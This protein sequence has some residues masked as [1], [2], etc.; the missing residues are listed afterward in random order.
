[1]KID[2]LLQQTP[3]LP[4]LPQVVQELIHTM[5]DDDV[6]MH[7]VAHKL[8]ADQVLSA[9]VLRLANSA[10]YSAP[11]TVATVDEALRMLGFRTVRTLVVSAGMVG[12]FQ[13]I[14]GINMP[15]FWRYG[16][17][18]AVGAK[19]LARLAECDADLAFTVGLLHSIGRLVMAAG[20]AD[21]MAAI[22]AS[23]SPFQCR[24]RIEAERSAFGFTYADVGAE[25]VKRW[26]FPDV[27]YEAIKGAAEPHAF[28]PPQVL[29]AVVHLAA[30]R[31]R[32]DEDGAGFAELAAAYP[33]SVGAIAGLSV[34]FVLHDMP[35]LVELSVG[36]EELLSHA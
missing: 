24:E 30:W 21:D 2:L 28:D 6:P 32:G 23:V 9:K 34:E 18:T 25:L 29:H 8:A 27:F 4:A 5:S 20:M 35:P 3:A 10:Y 19:H 33:L 13:P 1:M 26:N 7:E 16:L 11:R 31:A 22:P 12:S 36:L 14:A 17:H 15:R